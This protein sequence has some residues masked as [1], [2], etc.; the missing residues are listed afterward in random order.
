MT[1]NEFSSHLFKQFAPVKELIINNLLL[2]HIKSLNSFYKVNYQ[3]NSLSGP[4]KYSPEM[5]RFSLYTLVIVRS[6]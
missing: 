3:V 5:L 1:A 6:Y 4:Q 2:P